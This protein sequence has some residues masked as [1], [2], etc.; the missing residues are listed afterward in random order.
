MHVLQN[1][2][3]VLTDI[4]KE[5]Y[6]ITTHIGLEMLEAFLSEVISL[7]QGGGRY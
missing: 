4:N 7:G 5:E 3:I 6:D 2:S 1:D